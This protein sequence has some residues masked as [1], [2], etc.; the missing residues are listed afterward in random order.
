M[1][2]RSGGRSFPRLSR[3]LLFAQSCPV[4]G[5][6]A[7]PTELRRPVAKVWAPEPSRLYR[8]TAARGR[9][10]LHTLHDDPTATYSS[11]SGPKAMVRVVC[12]P[13]GRLETSVTGEDAPGSRRFTA[14]SS[15][16]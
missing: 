11:L 6:N 3:S 15:A 14:V 2:K 12:P 4:V 16:K 9:A 10:S 8:V 1:F 7:R 5:L 13:P